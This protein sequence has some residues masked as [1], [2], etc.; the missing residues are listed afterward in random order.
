[1]QFTEPED[2]F[3]LHVFPGESEPMRQFRAEILRLNLYCHRYKGA[4]PCVLITGETGVGKNFTARAISAHSQW[5]TLTQDE[6]R[7]L[8]YG[9]AGT[10]AFPA[11]QLIENLLTKEH[12]PQRGKKPERVP[13]LATVLG[14]QLADELAAS[15]LFG[16]KKHAFTGA[17]EDHAGI[18][19]DDSVDDI[20]L[21]EIADLSPKVQARLLQ[22]IETRT[23]RPVGGIASD[24]RSSDHRLF[25]ATNR[26][27]DQCVCEKRFR[28]DLYWRIQG[29]RIEIPPLRDRKQVIP[30]LAYSILKSVNHRQR[31]PEQIGP[32]LDP[33]Q[34]RYCLVRGVQQPA[35][36]PERSNWVSVL[37]EEDLHWCKEYHWPGN[38]RELRQRLDLYVYYNGHR[39]LKEVLPVHGDALTATAVSGSS[40]G[41]LESP[42]L[43]VQEAVNRYLQA[44]LDGRR[45]APN[46]PQYLL[47]EFRDMVTAAVYR[48]KSERHLSRDQLQAMF[49][50]A[51]D[52]ESTI[53]RWKPGDFAQ[54]APSADF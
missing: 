8:Y 3:L 1:M 10:I 54:T 24:E 32:C 4:I 2:E 41:A 33:E 13:R 43:L 46:Q 40:G 36:P 21:D 11:V 39:R 53:G 50:A 42:P 20:L 35:G 18:F 37:A 49:P 44:V 30:D 47:A 29:Y 7:E 22:F 51:K 27:L 9:S 52:A 19:G 25:L 6:R 31:G 28:E 14:P 23:F 12:L 16:H 48:F 38:V 45:P 17:D 26:P 5:L 15:E 34:D